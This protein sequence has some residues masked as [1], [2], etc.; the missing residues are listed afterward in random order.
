MTRLEL[1]PGH[2]MANEIRH[3]IESIAAGTEPLSS[4]RDNL[5]TMAIVDAIYR[6]AETGQ[7]VPVAE[8]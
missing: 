7:I 2:A 1:R 6:S 3:W 4:G 8:G 5:G